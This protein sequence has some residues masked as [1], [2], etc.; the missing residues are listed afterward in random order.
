MFPRRLWTLF[1]RNSEKSWPGRSIILKARLNAP[2]P[3]ER[4]FEKATKE[5]K[6][7]EKKQKD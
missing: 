3:V 2:S 7:L 6:Q 1:P 4:H 5:I